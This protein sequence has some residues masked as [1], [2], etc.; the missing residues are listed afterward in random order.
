MIDNSAE[1]G[2]REVRIDILKTGSDEDAY[3]RARENEAFAD[4][5]RFVSGIRDY[6]KQAKNLFIMFC[7]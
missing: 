6:E 7:N 1:N 5:L 4:L 3:T 2:I